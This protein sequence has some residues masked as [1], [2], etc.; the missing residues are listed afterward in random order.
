M[1]KI[2]SVLRLAISIALAFT[3]SCSS[4]GGDGDGS[5]PDGSNGQSDLFN[6]NPQVYNF[7][8]TAYKGSGIIKIE[9][10]DGKGNR[11]GKTLN[12]GSVTSGIVK[13]E[14]PTIPEEYLSDSYLCE[15]SPKDAKYYSPEIKLNLYNNEELVGNLAIGYFGDDYVYLIDFLYS[16]KDA[17]ITCEIGLNEADIDV[18]VDIDA[19]AGWNK[20][21]Y[22]KRN[23]TREQMST[24]DILKKAGEMKWILI[25]NDDH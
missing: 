19:K 14:L 11:N 5:W 2:K 9:M 18:K 4:G 22:I 20:V 23:D 25:L 21:Y 10:R 1:N 15:N 17:K 6:K 8:D 13:L 16:T 12:A 24:N 3:F 7:D